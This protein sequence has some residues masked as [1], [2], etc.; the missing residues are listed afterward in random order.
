MTQLTLFLDGTAAADCQL[1]SLA[2]LLG[3]GE[4]LASRPDTR[5]FASLL[6][7]FGLLSM[8]DSDLPLAALSR[9]GSHHEASGLWL[10]ADPVHQ[11]AEQDKVYL[12]GQ[13][14]LSPEESEEALRT[15]NKLFA[16]DGW[17]FHPHGPSRWLLQLPAGEPPQTSPLDQVLGMDIGPYLPRTRDETHWRRV[18]TEMQMLLHGCAFNQ[19]REERGMPTVNGVWLWAAGYLPAPAGLAWQAVW[20]EGDWLRGLAILHGMQ[21]RAAPVDYASWR[22]QAGEGSHWLQLTLAAGKTLEATWFAPLL[23]ALRRGELTEL[24][25]DTSNGRR[26]HISPHH[27]RRWWRRGLKLSE[28]LL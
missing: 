4:A 12:L 21:A 18:Q 19:E 2:R 10:F 11:V 17:H 9:L 3:R 8:P 20:G 26:W 14:T 1:P 15:L 16:E 5:P 7:S 27:L 22:Q 28:A 6:S 24:Q 25:I 23:Q 13:T